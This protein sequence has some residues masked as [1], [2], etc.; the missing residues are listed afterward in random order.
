MLCRGVLSYVSGALHFQ[1]VYVVDA[2]R[3]TELRGCGTRHGHIKKSRQ[4][5]FLRW[6]G[7]A[8]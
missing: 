7:A 5:D 6:L 4:G 1:A 2:E 3:L 8:H